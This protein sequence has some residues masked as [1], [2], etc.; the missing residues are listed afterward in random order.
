M[1]Y[2]LR[3]VFL[4]GE[5]SA[6]K[7]AIVVFKKMGETTSVGLHLGGKQTQPTPEGGGG[8]QLGAVPS[9]CIHHQVVVSLAMVV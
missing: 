6:Y 2:L 5:R 4:K 9:T 1:V 7:G 8:G 3:V